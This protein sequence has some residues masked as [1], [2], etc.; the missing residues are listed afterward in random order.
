[1]Y[2]KVCGITR[3]DDAR[4]A[5]DAGVDAIGLNLIPESKRYVSVELARTL[6]EYIGKEAH[7]IAVVA[8]CDLQQ[9]RT[10]LECTG[11]SRLQLHGHE[12]EHWLTELSPWA[13]RAAR[14]ATVQD[15][16]QAG[17]SLGHPLLVDAKVSGAL[18]GT[19]KRLDWP[20]VS[21]LAQQRPLL[22]A[23]GLNPGN[24]GQAIGVVQP[25]GVDVAS[26]VEVD[27]QP[28]KKDPGKIASFV[29]EARSA[30]CP[31]RKQ[32]WRFLDAPT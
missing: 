9:L 2:V 18:G 19:G 8:H 26:G 30:Y 28:R 22:L 12:P 24:V 6:R 31:Q 25:F 29:H 11:V 10:I 15:V 7:C 32:D 13:F 5:L 1:M 20:L 21:Q 23:G 27:G 16:E 4:A 14:I 3:L 17:N